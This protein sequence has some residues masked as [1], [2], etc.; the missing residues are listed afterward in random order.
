MRG[1]R[2]AGCG[3]GPGRCGPGAGG[4]GPDAGGGAGRPP[5]CGTPARRL[6]A[7]Y[8]PALSPRAP[9]RL[10]RRR[11]APPPSGSPVVRGGT[12]G[13]ATSGRRRG[14][15]GDRERSARL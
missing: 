6:P 15:R 8:A 9:R 14:F 4:G 12:V 5:G 13:A 10:P 1:R 7:P 2:V 3:A 11:T